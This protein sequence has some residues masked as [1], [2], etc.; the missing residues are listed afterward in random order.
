LLVIDLLKWVP[1]QMELRR[2]GKTTSALL[3]G[4][5]GTTAHTYI[6]LM[7]NISQNFPM[8]NNILLNEKA[9]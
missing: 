5:N 2:G 1:R 4:S 3:L 8:I 6:Y 9:D 7:Q